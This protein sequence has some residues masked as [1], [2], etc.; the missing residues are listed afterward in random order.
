[1]KKAFC[2]LSLITAFDFIVTIVVFYY[3]MA[4]ALPATILLQTETVDIL[5][6]MNLITALK[7]LCSNMLHNIDDYHQKWYKGVILIAG[8]QNVLE[9]NPRLCSKVISRTNQPS[10]NPSE[11]Y[12]KV[13]HN[14]S[15]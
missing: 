5:Q 10:S 14:S 7:D 1:M 2:F 15:N 3:I 11:Y 4:I 9:K 8:K 12:K 13:I 6:E